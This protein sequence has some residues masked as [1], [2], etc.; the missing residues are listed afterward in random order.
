MKV[1]DP[2]CP[3]SCVNM[4]NVWTNSRFRHS[5]K[6]D[7]IMD[8]IP[9]VVVDP[10]PASLLKHDDYVVLNRPY[11]VRE[12]RGAVWGRGRGFGAWGVAD[13]CLPAEA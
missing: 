6:P 4:C 13:A 3:H 1:V 9:T 8:Q 5:G 12:S 10:M 11:A 7:N 2:R